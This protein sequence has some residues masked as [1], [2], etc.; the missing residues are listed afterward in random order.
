MKKREHFMTK[1]LPEVFVS[2]AKDASQVYKELKKGRL[3]KLGSRVYTTNLKESA[4][5]LIKRHL[6]QI[7]KELFPDAVIVDRTALEHRPA[8]DGSIFIVSKK[9]RAVLLPGISIYPRKGHGPLKEDRP[10]IEK[11]FLSCPARAYLENLCKRRSKKGAVSRTLSREE[12]EKKLEMLLQGVGV[13]ALQQLRD[14]AKIIAPILG[15]KK[16]YKVLNELIGTFLGTHQLQ[17]KSSVAIARTQ[18]FPYDPK[19]LDLFQHFFETLIKTT[20][21]HRKIRKS[22]SSLPFF[23]AYFSNFIEGTEFQ[24][25]EAFEIIFEAVIPINRP[26]DAHDILGTYKIVSDENEMKTCPR[27]EEEL[28]TLL[29]RRHAL[30]MQGRPEMNPGRFKTVNNQAGMTLFVAPDLVEGTLRKGFQFLQGLQTPFQ[31]A[32][33]MMFLIAEV[34]PFADGNGRC[35]RIM[36][37]AELVTAKEARIIIPT[38]FRDNYLSALKALSHNSQYEPLIRTLDFA[39]NYTALIDWGD[40]EKANATLKSTHAFEDARDAEYRGMRLTLPS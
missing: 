11:L 26:K 15:R 40:F 27:N 33:F 23:E 29:K 28:I 31:R 25:N 14:E 16:E 20:I 5:I 34:H 38:V 35:A 12:V 30:I 39:Q 18:G 21:P 9:T 8:L 2:N 10:F 4:E 24:V 13:A 1:V 7:T 36:M 37:N 22:G 17:L 19:R 3:R 6:W 32:V